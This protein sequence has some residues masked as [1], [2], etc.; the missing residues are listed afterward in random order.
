MAHFAKLNSENKVVAIR[1]V[2]NEAI[3]DSD[4][5]ESEAL[6]QQL[7]NELYG[8]ATWKQC[9]Y[10]GS[11]RQKF[12]RIGDEYS[13]EHDAFIT[14]PLFPSWIFN[15]ETLAWTAPTPYPENAEPH[16]V[17]VWNEEELRW[18]YA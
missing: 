3:L 2:A 11:T 16:E 14:P 5:N 6:G 17:Y 13:E 7:L 15:E 12:P 1:V 9:S 4:G 10:N 18:Q 8:E